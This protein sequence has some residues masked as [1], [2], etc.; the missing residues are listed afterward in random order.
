MRIREF[1]EG[2]VDA[3]VEFHATLNP[4][5]FDGNYIK[6]DVREALLN[7]AKDFID[8][9]DVPNLKVEDIIVTGSNMGYSYTRYSDL[10]LHILV[11][12]K[13]DDKLL[14]DLFDAKKNQ[15]NNDHNFT[16]K[17]IDVELYVQDINEKHHSLGQYSLNNNDWLSKPEPVE[18]SFKDSEV[19]EK[20]SCYIGRIKE[21][22]RSDQVDEYLKQILEDLKKLRQN[23]LEKAGEFSVENI[24]YKVLRNTGIIP[25]IRERLNKIKDNH[26][27][28]AQERIK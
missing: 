23:G 22:L 17:G 1:R 21:A 24:A 3:A 14:K 9:L 20:V 12:I 13:G 2:I 27:S 19:E 15:Y 8:F 18:K 25:L 5:I 7:I 10:D 11:D 6:E 28:L 4:L 16:I 26:L